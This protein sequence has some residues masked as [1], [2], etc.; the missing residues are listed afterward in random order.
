[1]EDVKKDTS[2]QNHLD[3]SKRRINTFKNKGKDQDVSYEE[4]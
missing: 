2:N 3:E 4:N 1:M